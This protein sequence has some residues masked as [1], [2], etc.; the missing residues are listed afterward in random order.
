MDPGSG[1]EPEAVAQE[2]LERRLYPERVGEHPVL[3]SE[4]LPIMRRSLGARRTEQH[5]LRRVL[6]RHELDHL[7]VVPRELE[8]PGP[9]GIGDLGDEPVLVEPGAP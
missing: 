5:V 2:T 4:A 8:Q 3:R 1:R 6:E 7:N 9:C